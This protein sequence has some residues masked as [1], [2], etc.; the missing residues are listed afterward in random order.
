[1]F[2][3][4]WYY[5]RMKT[6]LKATGIVVEYNP[7]HNGHRY[8]IEKT[9][10]LTQCDVLIAVMS[11]HFVQRGEPA[12]LDKWVRTQAA[13]EYGVDIVVELPT[14][15]ALQS[16]EVFAKSSVKL[17]GMMSVNSLVY[18]SESL[19]IPKTHNIDK[20]M[21]SEGYSYAKSKNAH[22]LQS[23]QILGAYYEE[24]ASQY[25]IK[26]QRILRT[27][28]YHS[29]DLNDQ[30]ASASAIRKGYNQNLSIHHTT[31]LNIH[32]Y[33]TYHIESLYP[34]IRHEIIK[35]KES[36]ASYLMVDEGIENLFLKL[37]RTQTTYE[38]FIKNATSRRY[39]TSRIRRTLMHILLK[40]PRNIEPIH[41]VR[42]LG[43]ND[44]GKA[45]L[46]QIK[47]TASFTT[48]FKNYQF[49]DLEEKATTLYGIIQPKEMDHLLRKESG[50]P[51]II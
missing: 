36:L 8:H 17:L 46:H 10:E 16:A 1:M 37:A 5:T 21:L 47:N 29:L 26:T 38:D 39:T 48:S 13:L 24:A 40:T 3:N 51:I 6:Q 2:H 19:D 15:L 31:P 32:A 18:G 43:F 12:L 41:E 49:K 50:P 22:S 44:V 14:H 11:P 42:V 27:N 30:I 7:F 4:L 45:Y 25:S 34:F 33:P 20:V 23:N 28:A 35:E 9:R